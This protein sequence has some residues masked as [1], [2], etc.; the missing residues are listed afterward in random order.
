MRLIFFVSILISFLGLSGCGGSGGSSNDARSF[1]TSIRRTDHGI[2]HIKADNFAGLGY[3]YGYAVAQDNI[4]KL[5]DFYV[6]VNGERSKFFGADETFLFPANLLEFN[7]ADSDF[8]F[9]LIHARGKVEELMATPP[10][11]GP[12]EDMKALLRGHV[13]GYNRFLRD[14]GVDKLSDPNCRGAEWVREITE[15]DVY[16]LAYTLGVFA[17]WAA[18]AGGIG[19]AQPV[20]T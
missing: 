17:G 15:L 20:D 4:C 11:N 13:A 19:G 12:S 2:P 3:G 7:N 10:P 8:F 9:K 16:R 18:S 1:D 14:T 5:A 6:T